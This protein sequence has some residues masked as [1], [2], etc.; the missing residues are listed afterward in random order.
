[1][2]SLLPIYE[3]FYHAIVPSPESVTVKIVKECKAQNSKYD[4][5]IL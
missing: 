1:M 5:R 3:K 4:N 2:Y